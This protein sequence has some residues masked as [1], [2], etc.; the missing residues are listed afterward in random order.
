MLANPLSCRSMVGA[1]MPFGQLKRREFI[2]LLSGATAWP[3][4]VHAQQHR[5][6]VRLAFIPVGS[7]SNSYD[8]SLVEAFQQGLRRAGLLSVSLSLCLSVSG[9]GLC[10]HDASMVLLALY[11]FR[12]KNPLFIKG[13]N[14]SAKSSHSSFRS[15]QNALCCKNATLCYSAWRYC[16][17]GI[18]LRGSS[19]SPSQIAGARYCNGT[20]NRKSRSH[21]VQHLIDEPLHCHLKRFGILALRRPQQ[22]SPD[23]TL[24][25]RRV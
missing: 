15:S 2:T 1:V 11:S 13:L 9:I 10:L 25:V 20:T 14:A 22:L 17:G 18:P 21:P 4:A 7:P 12:V 8:R 6:P 24:D 3:L 23:E 19:P 5:G 16:K